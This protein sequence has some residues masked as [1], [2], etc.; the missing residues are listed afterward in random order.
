MASPFTVLILCTGNS[1]RSIMAEALLRH[2]AGPRLRVLS[3]GSHPKGE[4]DV[5]ALAA[6]ARHGVSTEGFAQQILGYF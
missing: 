1:C 2:L 3:A 6:L 5:G 4:V